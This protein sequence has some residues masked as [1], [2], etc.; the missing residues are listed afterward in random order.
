ML[1]YAGLKNCVTGELLIRKNI[2]NVLLRFF[3]SEF[4]ISFFRIPILQT[5]KP[6]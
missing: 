6:T 2:H 4:Q 1:Y 5:Y 3:K